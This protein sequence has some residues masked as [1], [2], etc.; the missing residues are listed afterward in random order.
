MLKYGVPSATAKTP[1]RSAFWKAKLTSTA[2]VAQ[3]PASTV[4]EL[5]DP[6]P[7]EPELPVVGVELPAEV[8]V[9]A[10]VEVAVEVELE[11][12]LEVP[13]VGAVEMPVPLPLP[14]DVEPPAVEVALLEEVEPPELD[15]AAGQ[16]APGSAPPS[17]VVSVIPEKLRSQPANARQ[18]PAPAMASRLLTR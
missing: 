15:G 6:A 3:G 16:V 7:L 14:L 12:A 17:Q 8:V 4:P 2:R 9:E 10:A 1:S 5:P 11:A 18:A 13:V